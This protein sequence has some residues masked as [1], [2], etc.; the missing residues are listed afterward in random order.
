MSFHSWRRVLLSPANI[1]AAAAQSKPRGPT[2]LIDEADTFIGDNEALR[3]VLNSGHKNGGQ[4]VRS[5][6][7]DF[8]Q[9][10]FSTHCPVAIAMIGRL[11]GTLS[12]RSIHVQM[13]HRMPGET[14]ARFRIAHTP[15]LT[16]VARKG[17]RWVQDNST[18]IRDCEPV[19]PVAI[20]NRSA[21]IGHRCLR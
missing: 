4:I 18:A 19:I 11:P 10:V 7:E 3:G 2:L 17:A 15:E 5:V 1:T 14:V 12:D 9:R 13:K 8:E 16:E 6:G 21:A 20:Y